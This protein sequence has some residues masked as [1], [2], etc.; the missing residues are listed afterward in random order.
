MAH[1]F[2]FNVIW[3]LVLVGK[4]SVM[5]GFT[6]C[7]GYKSPKKTLDKMISMIP[8]I[9]DD[10]LK[11]SQGLHV[12]ACMGKHALPNMWLT[13]KYPSS[14]GQQLHLY[15]L[16]SINVFGLNSNH[17]CITDDPLLLL[18]SSLL[19][20]LSPSPLSLSHFLLSQ[21]ATKVILHFI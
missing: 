8:G 7:S 15:V 13:Q 1:E 5:N 4:Y 3:H 11:F 12:W 21:K 14:P 20:Y 6:H 2:G 16:Q 19:S 17:N 10:H 9:A 18:F